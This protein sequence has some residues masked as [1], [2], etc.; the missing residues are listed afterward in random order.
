MTA[1][2]GPHLALRLPG[3]FSDLVLAT[4]VLE[5]A[6]RAVREDGPARTSSE[7]PPWRRWGSD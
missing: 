6:E 4:P 2:S 7:R 5:A 1:N 3:S